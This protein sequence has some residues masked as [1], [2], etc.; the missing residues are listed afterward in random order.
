MKFREGCDEREGGLELKI[1]DPQCHKDKN[2]RGEVEQAIAL[3]L[4]GKMYKPYYGYYFN[5]Q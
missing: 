2:A 1:S 3:K 4:K 5:F